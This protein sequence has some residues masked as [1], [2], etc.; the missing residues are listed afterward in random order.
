VP[1][2][3]AVVDEVADSVL[4]VAAILVVGVVEVTSR[5]AFPVV[6]TI[7]ACQ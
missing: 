3:V 2:Q 5:L 7:W 1:Q 6:E 4:L